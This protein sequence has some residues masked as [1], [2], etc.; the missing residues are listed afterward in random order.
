[1][2]TMG[3]AAGGVL[4]VAF[5]GWTA[6]HPLTRWATAHHLFT[7]TPAFVAPAA[8]PAGSGPTFTALI[9]AVSTL[10]TVAA[11][12]VT[13]IAVHAHRPTPPVSTTIALTAATFTLTSGV[14][15]IGLNDSNLLALLAGL[16]LAA[17]TAA[18][19]WRPLHTHSARAQLLAT[20]TEVTHPLLGYSEQPTQRIVTATGWNHITPTGLRLAYRGRA[21]DKAASELTTLVNACLDDVTVTVSH[22][23]KARQYLATPAETKASEPP[24]IAR[25]REIVARPNMFESSGKVT[26]IRMKKSTDA[27]TSFVVEHRISDKLADSPRP[28]IIEKRLSAV[29]PGGRWKAERW[30]YENDTVKFRLRPEFPRMVFPTLPPEIT[31]VDDTIAA[32]PSAKL[33]YAIDEDMNQIVWKPQVM[34]HTLIIGQTG[35]GKTALTQTLI[36]DA[37]RQGW[38]VV[39][40][41]FKAIE[42]TS[43]R[44][45]PNVTMVITKV[46]QAIAVINHLHHVMELRY[47]AGELDP[48]SIKRMMPMLVII[49]E[50]AEF[51]ERVNKFYAEHKPA[52]GA[53]RECPTV[54]QVSSILRLARKCRMHLSLGLQRPDMKI[55]ENGEARDNLG[56]RVSVGRLSGQGALMMWESAF[57]GRTVPVGVRGRATARTQ[58]GD[59]VEVQCYYTPDPVA[60]DDPQLRQI[61]E[62]LRPSVSLHARQVVEPPAPVGDGD[63]PPL[64]AEFQ[65]LRIHLAEDRPD[66]DPLSPHFRHAFSSAELDD[67]D[68]SSGL[69]VPSAP[70][71]GRDTGVTVTNPAWSA[72]TPDPLASTPDTTWDAWE[73]EFDAPTEVALADLE[74]GDLILIAGDGEPDRW[75]LLD[76][77]PEYVDDTHMSLLWRDIITGEVGELVVDSTALITR[78]PEADDPD[79]Q[80]PK[81]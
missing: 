17:A 2:E 73:E 32:Y 58:S 61:T 33:H 77:V 70:T 40:I 4:V 39:I 21:G 65:N 76:G 45:W 13:A 42:Y 64:F 66:L 3:A 38:P 57:V 5:L 35:S 36:V 7:Q 12:A 28:R 41:D 50:Y 10:I 25:L 46:E 48:S 79:R 49:D 30:D 62:A 60:E 44:D 11:L 24:A 37:T 51:M 6:Y 74:H 22:D 59:P 1:M 14:I 43:Y 67:F 16:L 75:G 56:H 23:I 15:V 55:M 72:P 80:G 20:L 9:L 81:T 78:R 71:G 29:L 34:P 26:E 69:L 31:S 18:A 68:V 63:E 53:P 19:V 47:Q 52:K 27:M 8:D 54:S